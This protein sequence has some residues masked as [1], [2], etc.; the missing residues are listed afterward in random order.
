MISW[1]RETKTLAEKVRQTETL[2][3]S[4]RIVWQNGTVVVE[5]LSEPT[6]NAESL[7]SEYDK[8]QKSLDLHNKH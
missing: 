3:V 6:I 4:T 8:M 2:K 5:E 1:K 7:M